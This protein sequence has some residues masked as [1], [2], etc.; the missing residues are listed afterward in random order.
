MIYGLSLDRF[1]AFRQQDI[2]FAPLTV[3]AGQ[4]SSGKSSIIQAINALLQST[5]GRAFPFDLVLNGDWAHLGGF[6]NVIHGHDAR[7]SFGIGI[8]F[9]IADTTYALS[10][11]F[12][13]ASEEGHLFPRQVRASSDSFG[14]LE[15]DWNQR[16][17]EFHMRLD[18]SHVLVDR[19]RKK[20]IRTFADVLSSDEI[21]RQT[22]MDNLKVTD[23]SQINEVIES[24]YESAAEASRDGVSTPASEFSDFLSFASNNPFFEILKRGTSEAMQQLRS[25]CSYIGPMRASPSRYFPLAG[26]DLVADSAGEG[27]SR[28][29]AKWKDR[30]SSLISQVGSALAQLELASDITVS[31]EHD[32]FLKIGI[33]P[34]GRFY[35]DSIADVGYG[36]S[37]VLPM[38]VADLNIEKGGTLLVNQP[39]IHL[40]PSSQALLANY[41]VERLEDKQYIIETHSEYLINRLRLL[42]AKGVVASDAIR[43]IYCS[44]DEKGASVAHSVR[45]EEDG[46]LTGAPKEFFSTYAA[47]AFGIAM[48]VIDD[49]GEDDAAE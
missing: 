10:A 34:H 11:T 27:T 1:R 9:N 13:Q 17:Q 35:S 2:E 4:N 39:E 32:E 36:L 7:N 33:K 41:F 47:D 40:H 25:R 20:F 42:V 48:A 14:H 12:K 26:G 29:L 31:V 24:L 21:R 6:K 15:I 23:P 45:I 18:P 28:T 37:Q 19:Q 3:I 30:K 16:A 5:Q 44:A 8:S 38:I 43:V 49:D 46:S 22:V